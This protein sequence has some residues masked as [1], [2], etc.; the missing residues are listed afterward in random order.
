MF[1]GARRPLYNARLC[2]SALV[3]SKD[4]AGGDGAKELL[5]GEGSETTSIAHFY[6]K[7]LKLKGMMKT[8]AGRQVREHA[9]KIEVTE[10]KM[11]D[12]RC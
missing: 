5:W 6:E 9:T 3:N 11:M 1:V 10:T 8:E 12:I 4:A 7:L 2:D